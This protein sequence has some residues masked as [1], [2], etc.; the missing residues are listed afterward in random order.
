MLL[1]IAPI[2]E[3]YFGKTPELQKIENQLGK[4]RSKYMQNYIGA[5]LVNNDP[6]LLK[7]NRMME[8]YF[9]FGCFSLSIIQT[10]TVNAYT[11]S[12]SST[13]DTA[14]YQ[15]NLIVDKNH[16]KFKSVNI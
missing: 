14:L 6:D 15:K 7:Y 9:G 16:F 8:K 11:T 4:F 12:V 2:N 3:V 5:P 10:P 13:F 1:N